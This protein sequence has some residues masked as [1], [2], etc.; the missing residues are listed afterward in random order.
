MSMSDFKLLFSSG[1]ILGGLIGTLSY[2]YNHGEVSIGRGQ[3]SQETLVANQSQS[4]L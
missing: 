4:F 1:S 3:F 2:L